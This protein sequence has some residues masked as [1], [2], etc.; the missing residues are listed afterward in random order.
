MHKNKIKKITLL[1][2]LT[3]VLS[4]NSQISNINVYGSFFGR[5]GDFFNF[6]KELANG[7]VFEW[8][9]QNVEKSGSYEE[10]QLNNN[11]V[12]T[13]ELGSIDESIIG[14]DYE[15]LTFL[16]YLNF[17][18][19]ILLN[20]KSLWENQ[21]QHLDSYLYCGRMYSPMF[22]Q[23]A[24]GLSNP[25]SLNI[26]EP[27]Y[28]Y[29]LEYINGSET[30]SYFDKF[31]DTLHDIAPQNVIRSENG[32]YIEIVRLEHVI[33]QDYETT[34]ENK[35]SINTEIGIMAFYR[36]SYEY[37][38]KLNSSNSEYFSYE[39]F[40]KDYGPKEYRTIPVDIGPIILSLGSLACITYFFKKKKK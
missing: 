27:I 16:V 40:S 39:I 38:D 13:V 33:K 5:S 15:L 28:F 32:K 18:Y 12:L 6:N 26:Y 2:C 7:S 8:K 30:I 11:D 34:E 14:A 20:G 24:F 19:G 31:Y 17:S 36:Y 29:P 4:F 10:I 21:T 22:Y 1:L 9:I 35:L 25:I 37:L 23:Y 3:Y